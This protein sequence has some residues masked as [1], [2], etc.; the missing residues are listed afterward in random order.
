[1]DFSLFA[2][3]RQVLDTLCQML[4]QSLR[5]RTNTDQSIRTPTGSVPKQWRPQTA[6]VLAENVHPRQDL[7]AITSFCATIT[8]CKP[9]GVPYQCGLVKP[10]QLGSQIKINAAERPK[11]HE[12]GPTSSQCARLAA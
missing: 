1:M 6:P 2:L 9:G 10:I 7:C 11:R 8:A 12:K 4:I 5:Q 3:V